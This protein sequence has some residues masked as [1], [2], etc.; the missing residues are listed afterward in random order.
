VLLSW[1]EE[2]AEALVRASSRSTLRVN[3][4]GWSKGLDVS[5][6]GEGVVLHAGLVLL[7]RLVDKSGLTGGLSGALASERLVVH[8]RGRV[9]ADLACAIAD[10]SEVI[11]DF[12]VLADQKELFGLVASVPTT[13]R[14]LSEI[15][16]GGPETLGR[17]SVAVA[18]ARCRAWAAAGARHGGLPGVRIADRVLEGVSCIRLDAT[19][20]PAHSEKERAEPNFKG[21]GHHPLLS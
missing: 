5:A 1:D 20:T 17:I 11:S 12:R 16:T 10:G 9:L 21:F 3:V 14:T 7:R 15:A 6:D 4:T 13:W 19:V 2:S 8:G 18:Q